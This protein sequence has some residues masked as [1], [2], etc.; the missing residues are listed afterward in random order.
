[1]FG[2][3]ILRPIE[4]TSHC[5]ATIQRRLPQRDTTAV[6]PYQKGCISIA[7]RHRA[8]SRQLSTWGLPNI[9]SSPFQ[10]SP[11]AEVAILAQS[12]RPVARAAIGALGFFGASRSNSCLRILP[13]DPWSRKEFPSPSMR[14][15]VSVK[16]VLFLLLVVEWSSS[17]QSASAAILPSALFDERFFARCQLGVLVS[18]GA[19]T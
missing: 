9:R 13:H 17:N 4:E 14:R 19:A 6:E 18:A 11:K 10:E 15:P 16:S 3:S 5:R 7:D 12:V 2:T 8:P 1:M